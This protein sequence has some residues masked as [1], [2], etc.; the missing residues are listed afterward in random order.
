MIRSL[1]TI[2]LAAGQLLSWSGGSLFVCIDGDGSYCCVDAGPESCECR[3]VD[4]PANGGRSDALGLGPEAYRHEGLHRHDVSCRAECACLTAGDSCGCT[5]LLVSLD[6]L[7]ADLRLVSSSAD[8]QRLLSR[9]DSVGHAKACENDVAL[10]TA[11]GPTWFRSPSATSFPLAVLST[12]VL[13][14]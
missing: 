13:R 9:L 5:H 8:F 11:L 2:A 6:S 10:A 7:P 4:G 12:V 3:H 1:L 14:C